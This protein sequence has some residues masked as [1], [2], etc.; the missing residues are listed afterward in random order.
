MEREGA[1]TRVFIGIVLM[2][3]TGMLIGFEYQ[4][5]TIRVLLA[6]GVDRVKLLLAK[7]TALSLFALALLAFAF[8]WNVLLATLVQFPLV[9]NLDAYRAIN[10][11][12][13][14]TTWSYTLT[15]LISMGATILLTTALT[16]FGRSVA[17]GVTI[18][19]AWFAADNIGSSIM[20]L[21][22]LFTNNDFWRQLPAY[23]LGPTL[24]YLPTVLV[25]KNATSIGGVPAAVARYDLTHALVVTLI[26][27]VVF[28]VVAIGLTWRRDVKE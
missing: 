1:I 16:V 13:W 5:G 23:W 10:S 11:T 9:G 2:I 19:F 15:V 25:G 20:S 21:V 6:R 24:N 4:H 22:Y 18:A 14:S 26:Y 17:F 28:F 7:V 12:L 27:S 3:A 8:V